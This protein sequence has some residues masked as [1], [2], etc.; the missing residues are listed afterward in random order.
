M[1]QLTTDFEDLRTE[2]RLGLAQLG[3]QMTALLQALTD[4]TSKVPTVDQTVQTVQE[5]AFAV[6]E[7]VTKVEKVGEATR[8]RAAVIDDGLAKLDK[9]VLILE[10]DRDIN[11]EAKKAFQE[12]INEKVAVISG[13]HKSLT[14]SVNNCSKNLSTF[15]KVQAAKEAEAKKRMD[16][17]QRCLQQTDL[18]VG[19][20]FKQKRTA[21]DA[22]DTTLEQL[23][24]TEPSGSLETTVIKDQNRSKK[25]QQSNTAKQHGN[26]ATLLLSNEANRRQDGK[27]GAMA[28]AAEGQVAS[29]TGPAESDM[30]IAAKASRAGPAQSGTATAGKVANR[31][32]PEQSAMAS[33]EKGNDKNVA[34][35]A[36][37]VFQKLQNDIIRLNMP[38]VPTKTSLDEG[39]WSEAQECMRAMEQRFSECVR[40]VEMQLSSETQE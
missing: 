9:K 15:K 23:L 29:R 34:D 19:D 32:G 36:S 13:T 30:A 5:Q 10:R 31:T 37:E 27:E 7:R 20:V 33:A 12:S 6:K 35:T 3:A 18:K 22:Y 17:L 11:I 1:G 40:A 8:L 25:G 39:R 28:S 2:L 4:S 14:T 16:D 21:N 26:A 24:R 38:L